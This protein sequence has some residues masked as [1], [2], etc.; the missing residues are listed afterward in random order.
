M[1]PQK[2]ICKFSFIVQCWKN[3]SPF[4]RDSGENASRF[5]G[6]SRRWDSTWSFWDFF[7][8]K[9]PERRNRVQK[10]EPFFNCGEKNAIHPLQFPGSM[11]FF[12]GRLNRKKKKRVI[13]EV[14]GF[15]SRTILGETIISNSLWLPGRVSYIKT[16]NLWILEFV[17][18]LTWA[19]K[20]QIVWESEVWGHQLQNHQLY[21]VPWARLE[22]I[23]GSG[24]WLKR[25]R[26]WKV[27]GKPSLHIGLFLNPLQ[28]PTFWYRQAI[29]FDLKV[30]R[31]FLCSQKGFGFLSHF[32]FGLRRS[33]LEI[34]AQIAKFNE[35]PLQA[36]QKRGLVW[37]RHFSNHGG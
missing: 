4:S 13:Y 21:M 6:E 35:L 37:H 17:W 18:S 36:T 34:L 32:A 22:K 30:I 29:Y 23:G 20:T 26:D 31:Q 9:I 33:D 16:L 7:S 10:T 27:D 12:H 15:T 14:W 24:V 8:W 25:Y 19:P 3:L 11:I 5:N 28:S 2:K 1:S